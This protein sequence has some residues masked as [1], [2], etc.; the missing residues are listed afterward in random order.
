[1]KRALRPVLVVLGFVIPLVLIRLTASARAE[2]APHAPEY[3]SQSKAAAN[4][5]GIGIVLQQDRNPFG[6]SEVGSNLFEPT[7]GS[8][9]DR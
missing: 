3:L 6:M 1:M 5:V 2:G 9:L 4:S 8:R 7:L